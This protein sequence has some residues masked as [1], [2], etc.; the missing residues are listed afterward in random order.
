VA[1]AIAAGA[2]AVLAASVFHDGDDTVAAIK[3]SLAGQGVRV[4]Q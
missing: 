1:D 4:R 2:G 3:G